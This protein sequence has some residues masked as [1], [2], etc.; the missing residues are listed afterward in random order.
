[1]VR[2]NHFVDLLEVRVG[3]VEGRVQKM[4][5]MEEE[6][7]DGGIVLLNYLEGALFENVLQE[8]K[9]AEGGELERWG[10]ERSKTGYVHIE[11][12]SMEVALTSS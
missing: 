4:E 12:F 9:R 2:V 7:G 8:V 6:Q 5:G 11:T 1:M 3:Y 10:G